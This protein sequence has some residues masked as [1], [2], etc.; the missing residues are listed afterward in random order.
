MIMR[1]S[2]LVLS[3]LAVLLGSKGFCNQVYL[4]SNFANSLIHESDAHVLPIAYSQPGLQL[5]TEETLVG[6][7]LL[8]KHILAVSNTASGV[9]VR[10]LKD[11]TGEILSEFD[12]NTPSSPSSVLQATR[13]FYPSMDLY[14]WF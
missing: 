13:A 5:A 10:A 2:L 4:V 8:G 1:T 6:S 12:L 3:L 9:K 14:L 7:T 11:T